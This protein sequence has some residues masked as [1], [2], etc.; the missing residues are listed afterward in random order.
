MCPYRFHHR[1]EHLATARQQ[2]AA[3][4]VLE[5]LE[6]ALRLVGGGLPKLRCQQEP[7]FGQ[8]E[9]M[10]AR[11]SIP[12]PVGEPVNSFRYHRLCPA[13]PRLA[14]QRLSSCSPNPAILDTTPNL[15]KS[16][17]RQ[18]MNPRGLVFSGEVWPSMMK[19]APLNSVPG[20][21]RRRPRN[22]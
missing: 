14:G 11:Y 9:E 7:F 5:M 13:A 2:T 19:P 16:P 6:S 15:K 8:E 21:G 10:V 20:M 12:H 17:R 18:T 4:T 22:A 3:A 1:L